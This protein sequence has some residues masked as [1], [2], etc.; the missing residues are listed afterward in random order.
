[1]SERKLRVGIIGMGQ[2][3]ASEHIP[4]LR[5][6]GRA[7]V[8][9]AARRNPERLA[10]AQRELNIPEVYTDWREMLTRTNLDAVVVGTPHNL[11]VEPTLAALERGLHVLLEKPLATSV[12]DAHTIL[13][14]VKS[15]DRVVAMG[16]NRR[17]VPSW[18][19]AQQIIATGQ[20]GRLRQITAVMMADLRIFREEM[21]FAQS[22]LQWLESSEIDRVFLSDIP[23][24]GSWR[25]DPQ[26]MGGDMFTDVGSHLVD[27]M[28]WLAGAPAVEVLAYAPKNR[29][30]GAAVLTVQALLANDV[31]L[32][33]T[34]NDNI[35]MGDEFNFQGRGSLN[36]LG[37]GGTLAIDFTG[38]GSTA[39]GQLL[40]EKN[41]VRQVVAVEG[42]R[43][44]PAQAFVASVLDGAPIQATVEDAARVVEF[45]QAAYRSSA[46]RRIIRIDGNT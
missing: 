22:V 20:I 3:A 30:Q 14:A 37:D 38:F 18:Q 1:M 25:N 26:Q 35:A 46:E 23:K 6:T 44:S 33:I 17:G 13:H 7:E 24:P 42:S 4:N 31:I 43:I 12:A 45:V 2:W 8:V 9:S 19:T 28:L 16:V 32:S 11:H 15:S 29:P 21:P 36:A 10:L 5:A 40:L 39:E 34:F 41:G 27:V